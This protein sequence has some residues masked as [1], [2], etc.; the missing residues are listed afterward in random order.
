MQQLCQALLGLVNVGLF[1][2]RLALAGDLFVVGAVFVCRAPKPDSFVSA[3]E[4]H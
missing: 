4:F 3:G 2:I 1:T